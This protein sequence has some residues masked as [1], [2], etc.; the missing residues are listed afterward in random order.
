M[1]ELDFKLQWHPVTTKPDQ[2]DEECL[3]FSKPILIHSPTGGHL[4]AVYDMKEDRWFLSNGT[5]FELVTIVFK[6]SVWTYAP[7]S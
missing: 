1:E 6:D 7:K 5:Q 3:G 2:E 4:L